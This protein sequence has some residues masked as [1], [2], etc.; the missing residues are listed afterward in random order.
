MTETILFLV[1]LLVTRLLRTRSFGLYDRVVHYLRGR[2]VLGVV[3]TR[4]HLP[5]S[6]RE[7]VT[8]EGGGLD[9]EVRVVL[10]L[11]V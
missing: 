10:F 6:Y 9:T 1:F 3:D 11:S 8:P 2:S 7:V 4:G 5:Y